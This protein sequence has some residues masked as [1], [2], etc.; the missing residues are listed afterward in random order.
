VET[1]APRF[2]LGG[3]GLFDV[4]L[5]APVGVDLPRRRLAVDE[6]LWLVQA[7]R[8]RHEPAHERL[9]IVT[10]AVQRV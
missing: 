10:L 1:D 7:V 2:A 3:R 6:E 5:E 8:P 4:D 9:V